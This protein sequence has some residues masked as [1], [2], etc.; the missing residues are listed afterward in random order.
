MRL[1]YI[2][3][4][5]SILSLLAL[6][7][8]ADTLPSVITGGGDDFLNITEEVADNTL[9][10]V[11]GTSGT[12]YAGIEGVDITYNLNT[13]TTAKESFVAYQ[14]NSD[15]EIKNNIVVNLDSASYPNTNN[16]QFNIRNASHLK[17]NSLELVPDNDSV[18]NYIMFV[19]DLGGEKSKITYVGSD[20]SNPYDEAKKINNLRG[21]I[22][23]TNIEFRNE[24]V[25][26][27]KS[28]KMNEH[29][30]L[31]M[32][33]DLNAEILYV[34]ANFAINLNGND[35]YSKSGLNV[36]G[37]VA[38][39]VITVT[40]GTEA[41]DTSTFAVKG[42]QVTW[43]DSYIERYNNVRYEFTDYDPTTDFIYMKDIPEND[44]PLSIIGGEY[45]G[46]EFV[47][48]EITEGEYAGWTQYYVNIP[49]PSHIAAIL[50]ALSLIFVCRR[51][52]S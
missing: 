47:S 44:N 9:I 32:G 36:E 23:L 40:F 20:G 22:Y 28:F 41:G 8:H 48:K 30:V 34:T 52:R 25:L 31:N 24:N 10:D 42:N 50:G 12:A 43:N 14:G 4:Y 7:L 26:T 16:L 13:T 29:S 11:T 2:C 18:D 21:M 1:P 39:R 27:V 19:N 38:D 45:A 37:S 33:A 46:F 6:P 17:I 5:S 49:E 15:F 3:F 51:R 35:F